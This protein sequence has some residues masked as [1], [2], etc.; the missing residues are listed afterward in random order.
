MRDKIAFVLV[1]V[2]IAVIC[3]AFALSGAI[4]SI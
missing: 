1:W 2:A 4:G 3:A